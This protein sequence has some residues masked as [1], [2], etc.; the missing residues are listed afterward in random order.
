MKKKRFLFD[1]DGEQIIVRQDSKKGLIHISIGSGFASGTP[2]DIRELAE[3]LT[4]MA[5]SIDFEDVTTEDIEETMEEEDF[6]EEDLEEIE[7]F[8]FDE[9]S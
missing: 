5:E 2:D 8:I 3:T 4:I 1:V 6:D 9:D 7:D